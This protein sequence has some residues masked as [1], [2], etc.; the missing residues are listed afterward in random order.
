MNQQRVV[1]GLDGSVTSFVALDAAAAEAQL[2]AAELE[3][4]TCGPDPDE[5]APL[6]R[7]ARSR[8]ARRHPGLPVSTYPDVGDPA[9]VLVRR[10]GSAALTVVGCR[11]IGGIPGLL[12][13]SVSRRVAAR[14]TAPLLVT[15]GADPRVTRRGE[16]AGG[17][18]LGMESDADAD[19]ALFAFE[20]AALR[21]SRL[22][23]L[24]AWT[25]RQTPPD[26]AGQVPAEPVQWSIERA[27]RTRAA[28]Q[29][30]FLAPLRQTHPHLTV[31]N[32]AVRATPCRALIE[33]TLE[34]DMVVIGA[35]PRC[36]GRGSDP[37]PVTL[38]LLR[39]AHCP[40]AIVPHPGRQDR[41]T[42]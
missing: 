19:A 22:D 39:H 34:A 10:G 25:Y 11:A 24:H 37:G 16:R 8:V 12:L 1:V 15:R 38:A 40:V 30:E 3:V 6:L 7:A 36:G 41:A 29:G 32:R 31:R 26:P 18:L 5:A 13:P 2:R 33:A 20:E 21:G 17:L 28:R 4:V 9:D 42:D 14:I 23:V 27:T 35:R